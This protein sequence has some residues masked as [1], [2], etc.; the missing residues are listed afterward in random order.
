MARYKKYHRFSLG[1]YLFGIKRGGRKRSS[2]RNELVFLLA[3]FLGVTLAVGGSV[4]ATSIGSN[5]TVSG[6]L[7]VQSSS[8]TST[9]S[10]GGVNVGAGQ[11]IIQQTTGRV[12]VGSTT[13]WGIL[14]SEMT[15]TDPS[16]VVANNGSTTPAFYV[17]GINQNG[18]VGVASSTPWGILSVGMSVINDPIFV[19]GNIGSTTAALYVSGL[20]Q[21]G[22]VGISSSTP[23]QKL[24]V[25]GSLFVGADLGGGA[26]GGLGVG[27]ATTTAGAFE[28]IGNALFGDAVGDTVNFN[29]GVLNFNNL[30]TTTLPISVTAFDIA[31]TTYGGNGR[32]FVRLDTTNT[33]FGIATSVPSATL[34]VGGS[35]MI[36]EG[37]GVGRATTTAGVLDVASSTVVT[38][39]L[40]I[41]AGTSGTST[42]RI[43]NNMSSGQGGCIELKTTAGATVSLFATTTGAGSA[44]FVAGP[45]NP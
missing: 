9:I 2:F 43:T 5:V 36:G 6:T 10:T 32:P 11:F 20:N 40:T 21:D 17:S 14:S 33:R 31:T 44:V 42:L 12:G 27:K 8:A 25:G 1:R 38:G 4:W 39:R 13:P 16:F 23:A 22:R 37:L 15:T 45:C 19:V 30:S 24:S 29:A 26:V 41:G 7:D 28:I 3:L 18:R 35:G 34:S